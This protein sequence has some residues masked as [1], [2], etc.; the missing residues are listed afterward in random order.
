[1]Y[2]VCFLLWNSSKE[3]HCK[4]FETEIRRINISSGI[5]AE[6]SLEECG[7]ACDA[8][9]E[10]YGLTKDEQNVVDLFK[11]LGCTLCFV[12][13]C[14]LIVNQYIDQRR[15]GKKFCDKPLLQIVCTIM[16]YI[17]DI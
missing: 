15:S 3:R 14:F 13:I 16:L 12:A 9:S 11:I 10:V 5:V 4:H 2:I 6:G 1:M 7:L 8:G 17:F